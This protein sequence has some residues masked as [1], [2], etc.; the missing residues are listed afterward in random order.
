MGMHSVCNCT[1]T[2]GELDDAPRNVAGPQMLAGRR[3]VGHKDRYDL[4]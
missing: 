3:H 1:L 4:A 2:G